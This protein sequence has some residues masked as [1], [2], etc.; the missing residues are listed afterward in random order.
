MALERVTQGRTVLTVAHRLSTLR[1]ADRI[2]VLKDG[3][4]AEHGGHDELLALGGAYARLELLQ[5]GARVAPA[6]A[7]SARRRVEA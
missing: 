2:I 6:S 4:A 7:H 3:R 5:G 1:D